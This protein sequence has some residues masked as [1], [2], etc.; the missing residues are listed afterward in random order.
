MSDDGIST[1]ESYG[2]QPSRYNSTKRGMAEES[3]TRGQLLGSGGSRGARDAS[4]TT[5]SNSI[6]KNNSSNTNDHSSN[7]NDH[8]RFDINYTP[9]LG[10]SEADSCAQCAAE[11]DSDDTDTRTRGNNTGAGPVYSQTPASL[12]YNLMGSGPQP[13]PSPG[14]SGSVAA[15]PAARPR[16]QQQ[17][18]PPQQQQQQPISAAYSSP[19]VYGAGVAGAQSAA[20]MYTPVSMSNPSIYNH[21]QQQQ[22]QQQQGQ[23][24]PPGP[25]NAAMPAVGPQYQ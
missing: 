16:L 2:P 3:G 25:N 11:E 5:T 22:P 13:Y 6:S 4:H 15:G 17:P 23:Y 24:G 14:A 12:S 19:A 18:P 9:P 1:T 8:I 10:N 21:Q 7:T 20:Q